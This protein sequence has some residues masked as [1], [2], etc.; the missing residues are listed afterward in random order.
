MQK[1]NKHKQTN[2]QKQTKQTNKQ[3]KIKTSKIT[4]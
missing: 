4:N 3:A 1:T 2:K